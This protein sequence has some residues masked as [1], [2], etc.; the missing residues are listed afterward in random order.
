MKVNL[1]I[2]IPAWLDRIFTWPV[3]MYRKL[4]YGCA[5]RRLYLGE[6]YYTAVDQDDFL[7]LSHLKWHIQGNEKKICAVRDVLIGRGKTRLRSLHREIMGN[8]R[9]LLV[10]H[11]NNNPL[12][13]RSENLRKATQSQNQQNINKRKNTTSRFVG[14]SFH[15]RFKKWSVHI[16]YNKKRIHLGY[17]DNEIDAARA[18]DKAARKYYGKHARL[19]FPDKPALPELPK[20]IF[21]KADC[22][23]ILR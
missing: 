10:D 16:N 5:F 7:R 17:F 8:P 20:H 21:Y 11:L 22:Q 12:D 14:V 1:T 9:K 15:S 2:R 4:K 3:L 19:N 13:N 18:Y 6:G 23:R